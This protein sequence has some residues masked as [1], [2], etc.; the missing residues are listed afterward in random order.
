MKQFLIK[1]ILFLLPIFS[2]L[3][4]TKEPG[5]QEASVFVHPPPQPS[6]DSLE[7][8]SSKFSEW[9]LYAWVN[10][11]DN[12]FPHAGSWETVWECISWPANTPKPTLTPKENQHSTIRGFQP[13]KYVI[14]VNMITPTGKKFADRILEVVDD[15]RSGTQEEFTKLSWQIEDWGGAWGDV[16]TTKVCYLPTQSFVLLN[17]PDGLEPLIEYREKPGNDWIE[18]KEPDPSGIQTDQCQLYKA[19]NGASFL[20]YKES[21]GSIVGQVY[22]D[23]DFRVR[24]P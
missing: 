9:D 1:T 21:P 20:I 10:S 14:R 13:G 12:P 3:G 19:S 4:C 24:Y 17:R 16:Y 6:M 23:V 5:N 15:N 2:V 7:F 11:A 22:G 8:I 18:V